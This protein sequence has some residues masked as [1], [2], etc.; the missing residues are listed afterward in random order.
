MNE[1][2]K[3]K[4]KKIP[5]VRDKGMSGIKGAVYR[6]EWNSYG[7]NNWTDLLSYALGETNMYKSIYHGKEGLERVAEKLRQF[8]VNNNKL[9]RTTDKEM[10]GIRKALYHGEWTEFN[11][12]SWRELLDYIFKN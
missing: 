3:E 8:K 11:I 2:L 5:R 9:P 6:G 7:I 10:N 1:L 12:K 4:N